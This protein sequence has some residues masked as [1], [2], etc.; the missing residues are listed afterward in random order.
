[1]K[2]DYFTLNFVKSVIFP[3]SVQMRSH[4]KNFYSVLSIKKKTVHVLVF[5]TRT[6]FVLTCVEF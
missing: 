2:L 4:L 5:L 1:M 6:I 3:R